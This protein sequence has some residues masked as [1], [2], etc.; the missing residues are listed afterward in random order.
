V[1]GECPGESRGAAAGRSTMPK[2]IRA[3]VWQ[4]IRR[5]QQWPE[6]SGAKPL[7]GNLAGRYRLRTG[8]YRLQFRIEGEGVIIEQIGHRAGFYEE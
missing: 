7:R 3:R 5:L 8:D 1:H 6:I 4:L 2:V